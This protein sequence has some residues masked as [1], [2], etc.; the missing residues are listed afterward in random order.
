M[1]RTTRELLF[2]FH[3]GR[4]STCACPCHNPQFL[5]LVALR[6]R[7]PLSQVID[8]ITCTGDIKLPATFLS[9]VT[10]K[11]KKYKK[12]LLKISGTGSELFPPTVSAELSASFHFEVS[13]T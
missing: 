8:Y 4:F 11:C 10:G 2:Y 5:P 13:G 9:F 12:V 1:T 6:S 3:K 7:S